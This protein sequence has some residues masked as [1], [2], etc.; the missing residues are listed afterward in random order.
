MVKR[1]EKKIEKQNKV[2][3]KATKTKNKIK[4][5]VE[6]NRGAGGEKKSPSMM[7]NSKMTSRCHGGNGGQNLEKP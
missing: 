3:T 5:K 4:K 7:F 1:K 6:T 2:D